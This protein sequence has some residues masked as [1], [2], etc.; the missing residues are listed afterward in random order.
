MNRQSDGRDYKNHC[1]APGDLSQQGDRTARPKGC[2]THPAESRRNINIFA[3]LEEH[4][5]NQQYARQDVNDLKNRNHAMESLRPSQ[6]R[7]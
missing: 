5:H 6:E 1:Q 4:G 3:T 2:L 7:G